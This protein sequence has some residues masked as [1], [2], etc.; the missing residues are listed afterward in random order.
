MFMWMVLGVYLAIGSIYDKKSFLLPSGF[1]ISGSLMA[2]VCGIYRVFCGQILWQQWITACMPGILWIILAFATREQMGYG[3]GMV[4]LVVGSLTDLGTTMGLLMLGLGESCI[5][6]I[7]LLVSKR[8]NRQT[9]IPFVPMLF[10]SYLL[11]MGG[12]LLF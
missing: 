8:G 9:P 7:L 12:R 10:L 4:L 5:W 11:V 1:L 6:G 2:V 3:D